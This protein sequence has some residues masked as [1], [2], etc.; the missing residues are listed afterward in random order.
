MFWLIIL[1]LILG[2]ILSKRNRVVYT[3]IGGV[4]GFILS[5]S[6]FLIGIVM[7]S[8]IIFVVWL[9]YNELLKDIWKKLRG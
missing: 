9:K 3:L 5:F 6:V 7:F 2:F 4:V 1:G 8:L